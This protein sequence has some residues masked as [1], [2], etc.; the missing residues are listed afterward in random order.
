MV[1]WLKT[2]PEQKFLDGLF[3]KGELKEHSTSSEAYENYEMFQRV[4]KN[5]FSK[6]FNETKQNFLTPSCKW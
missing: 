4:S 3:E 6:H 2:G 5:V 1:R